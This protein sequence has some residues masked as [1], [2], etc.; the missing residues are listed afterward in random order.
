M[1]L[2]FMLSG[3]GGLKLSPEVEN[4]FSNKTTM[5]TQQ[6]MH[7]NISRGAKIVDATNYQVGILIPANSKVTMEEINAKQVIFNYKGNKI[8]LRN[9]PKYTGID[10]LALFT[11]SFAEKKVDIS[12]FTEAEQKEIRLAQITN[13]M[14]KKAVLISLGVPPAH[15]TPTTEMNRWKYWRTRFTTF[16]VNFKNGKVVHFTPNTNETSSHSFSLH[17]N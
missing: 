11:R 13:N 17:I 5:Y 10:M 16:V 1:G 3:C 9:I 4:V 14:S 2:G 7:Y 6:N 12:L 15:V 8:I